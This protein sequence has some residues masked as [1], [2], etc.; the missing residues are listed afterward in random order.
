MIVYA[1]GQ[2][3][4]GIIGDYIKPKYMVS[5]GLTIASLGLFIFSFVNVPILGILSFGI[6]GFG[7][8]MLRGP[9][10]KVISENTLTKYARICCVF[11][12][13][14]SFAGP[15]L[16]GLVAMIMKWN[17][18]FIFSAIITF[19]M[20]VF[21]FL[22]LTILEKRGMI[23]PIKSEKKEKQKFDLFSLF[24]LHNFLPYMFVGM[25]VEIAA[26]SISYWMPT[27]F[28]EHLLLSETTSR[29]TFSLI[30]L[31][32]SMCPFLSLFI[33]KL[34]KQK[35]VLIVR[36]AFTSSAVLFLILF[37][38]KN[39]YLNLILFTLALMCSSISSSTLW[40]IYIPSLGKS[41]KVSS[42][43]GV[44]DCSGYIAAAL[45]NVLVV[46]IMNYGGWNGVIISW[47]VIMAFGASVTLFAKNTP[48]ES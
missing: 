40:S 13:F 19:S 16:A 10:V 12:S 27:F 31:I 32:R 14:A 22:M 9:L 30:S 24:K 47:C 5:I 36:T 44:L 28:N 1:S 23:V 39:T 35:D 25:V 3:L 2:L 20:A 46:P 42:V 4:N 43:N 48:Q 33:F 41:G 38:V 18:V 11:L 34:F 21:S 37:F 7:L 17:T 26:A 8:S 15:L 45:A 6:L 29:M